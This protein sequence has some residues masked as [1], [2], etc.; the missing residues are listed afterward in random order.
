MIGTT[1]IRKEFK[2][3]ESVINKSSESQKNKVRDIYITPYDIAKNE[4]TAW[5]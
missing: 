1:M 4:I 3:A 5:K 2:S